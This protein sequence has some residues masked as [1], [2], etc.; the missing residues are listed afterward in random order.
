M[1]H[2]ASHPKPAGWPSLSRFGTSMPEQQRFPT[3]HQ[4]MNIPPRNRPLNGSHSWER[5]RCDI[6]DYSIIAR[7]RSSNSIFKR[8]IHNGRNRRTGAIGLSIGQVIVFCSRPFKNT[9]MITLFILHF[10]PENPQKIPENQ[11]SF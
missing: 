11:K 9:A 3:P 1:E 2:L 8:L 6:L 7:T 4:K 10:P 5:S